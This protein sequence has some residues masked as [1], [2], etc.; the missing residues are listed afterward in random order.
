MKTLHTIVYFFD[1][2][3]DHIRARLA[4]HPFVYGFVGGTGIVLFWRGVW[5][6]ADALEKTTPFFQG[7]FSPGGS[8]ILGALLLLSTGLFVSVFIGD[9]IIL[10]GIK[11]D[12]KIIEKTIEDVETEKTDLEKMLVAVNTLQKELE[13][14]EC[15]L[16][17]RCK[18]KDEEKMS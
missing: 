18:I 17:H 4:R 10:S 2:M 5:H 3:E 7:L 13:D 6:G 12:K 16:L 14:I 11:H 9:S 1:K 8:V 15:E